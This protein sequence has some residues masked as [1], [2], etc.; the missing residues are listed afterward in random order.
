MPP[1]P[2][3]TVDTS[4]D[5]DLM[6]AKASHILKAARS[7]TL[8]NILAPLLCIPMFQDE[9]REGH[10][11][12]WLGYMFLAIAIRTWIIFKL[13]YKAEAITNPR[14]DL[15]LVTFA[16]GIV[17]FGWGLGWPLM[18]PD[19]SMVNRMIYVYMTTAAMISSM[20]AY[21]VNKPT[22]YWF[23]L[24]IM[25]PAL[26]SVLWPSNLFP[27]PFSVGLASLYVVV[28]S[29]A[30]SFSKTFED[31]V[32]LRFRNNKLYQELANERDQ[33]VAANMA[34]SKYIAVAS[35][36]M[37]QPMHAIN[38]Y[39]ELMDSERFSPE[40]RKSFSKIRTSITTL[41]SMFDS[42]LNI[43]KLDAQ[44]MQATSRDFRVMDLAN[45]VQ[46]LMESRADSKGL[47]LHIQSCDAVL[48]G[49][50]FILQQIIC[51]LVSNAIQYTEH[52]DIHVQLDQQDQRLFIEVRDTGC[53]IAP[54]DQERIFNEFYR[55]DRTR[56]LH[57]G[58][59]LGLSIVKRLCDLIGADIQVAS[60]PGQGSKFTVRTLYRVASA[61]GEIG[62]MEKSSRPVDSR[63]SLQGKCIAIIED[64]PVIIEAYRQMLA[65]KGAHVQVLSEH[66]KERATQL[67]SVD[68][69]DCILS[70][71][72][73]SHSTGDLLIQN[74]RENYNEEIPALIVTADTS[75]AHIALFDKLNVPVLHKPI[76]F[77]EVVHVIEKLVSTR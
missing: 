28:L 65:G 57:D 29:I 18:T 45:A 69:I 22:F 34:K 54:S 12:L 36:D 62:Q 63:R 53:G 8:A 2:S 64:N 61:G 35:H 41:N 77:Q 9:V 74:I 66:E 32:R 37:R 67:E 76:S 42:L 11:P 23:T 58:L 7:A 3:L 39:L 14:R 75:P 73:L 33:S 48:H 26:S 50:R 31:S 16:V 13:D 24:P 30:N 1:S 38:V 59:G 60:T 21:S 5:L 68:H 6:R 47:T 71:Y 4:H 44:L 20:F 56:V 15:Q 27:W 72:R 43:S 40:D 49:D 19:L 10:L 25:V 46:D 17:G 55:V 52:G 70:D 51:N